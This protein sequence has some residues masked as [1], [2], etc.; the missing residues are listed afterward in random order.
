M[1]FFKLL[2]FM[3]GLFGLSLIWIIAGFIYMALNQDKYD[4]KNKYLVCVLKPFIYGPLYIP[5]K[6]LKIKN[7]KGYKF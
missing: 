6:I 1:I 7:K 2:F 3:I 5:Y 4:M